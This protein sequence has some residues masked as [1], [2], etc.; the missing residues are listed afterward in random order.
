MPVKSLRGGALVP[1]GDVRIDRKTKWGNPF[2]MKTEA[3]RA[4]VIEDYR[5][6]SWDR[7]HKGEIPLEDLAALH[8]KTLWC[9]CHPRGCHGHVLEK[10][11]TWAHEQIQNRTT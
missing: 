10:A 11:A 2:P 3:D 4:K 7:I 5:A 1:P 9:W 8:G 6:W